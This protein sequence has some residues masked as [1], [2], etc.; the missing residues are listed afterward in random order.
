MFDIDFDADT[1]TLTVK[2][3]GPFDM[4]E[5]DTYSERYRRVVLSISVQT[6]VVFDLVDW[7]WPPLDTV[8]IM[9]E[10]VITL[11]RSLRWWS[12]MLFQGVVLITASEAL[13]T[14][15]STLIS[16]LALASPLY[17]ASSRAEANPHILRLQA[18]IRGPQ[19][20]YASYMKACSQ[21]QQSP[22]EK[23]CTWR[24][25]G[26]GAAWVLFVLQM[27]RLGSRVPPKPRD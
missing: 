25:L 13:T 26:V 27:I 23:P 14:L 3:Y 18:L 19:D 12:G 9:A 17:C 20:G 21:L 4:K 8:M 10:K 7:I 6:V 11:S 24:E 1:H 5:W 16:K 15:V 22:G 2:V